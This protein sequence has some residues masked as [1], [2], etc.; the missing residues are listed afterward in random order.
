MKVDSVF[1]CPRCE[2]KGYLPEFSHIQ[3]GVCFLCS[4][5]KKINRNTQYNRK[6]KIICEFTK[7]HTRIYDDVPS[8]NTTPHEWKMI[9]REV[10]TFSFD[11]GNRWYG[12]WY[13]TDENRLAM[14]GLWKWFKQQGS[15]MII[16]DEDN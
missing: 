7:G 5:Q 6:G 14:R 12:G 4:G 3:G 11:G 2:S 1:D 8:P 15:Q 10:L 9:Y 13:I 16:T